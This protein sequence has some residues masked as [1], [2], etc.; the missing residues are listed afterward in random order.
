MLP[1]QDHSSMVGYMKGVQGRGRVRGSVQA[2]SSGI[3]GL[4]TT[5]EAFGNSCCASAERDWW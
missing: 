2:S 1:R 3:S 4:L 5:I